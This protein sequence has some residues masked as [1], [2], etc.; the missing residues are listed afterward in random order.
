MIVF[1]LNIFKKNLVTNLAKFT[2]NSIC[3][4]IKIETDT[5]SIFVFIFI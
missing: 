3:S 4:E 2:E 5:G 1:I